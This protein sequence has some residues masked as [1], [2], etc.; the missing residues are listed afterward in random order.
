VHLVK[1]WFQLTR[2]EVLLLEGNLIQWIGFDLGLSCFLRRDM[3]ER[4][5]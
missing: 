2:V 3:Q 5:S 1:A 4:S